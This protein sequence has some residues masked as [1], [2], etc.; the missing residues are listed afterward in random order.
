[1]VVCHTNKNIR[2]M[3]TIFRIFASLSLLAALAS[4]QMYEIDTQ[5]TPAQAAASLRMDC[6]ALATY[7]IPALAPQPLT[8]NVS[9]NTPWRITRSEGSEWLAVSPTS[10]AA[11]GLI[12][13]VVM[14]PQANDTKEDRT[15]VLT[16]AGDGIE[17]FTVIKVIQSR[18]GDLEVIPL[19]KVF[20]AAGGQLPFTFTSNLDWEIKADVDWLTFSL[21]EGPGDGVAHHITITAAASDV[22]ERTGNV[23][24][25]AGEESK[26]FAVSQVGKFDVAEPD[27]VIPSD[28]GNIT[29]KLRTDLPWEIVPD[30]AWVTV[31]PLSQDRGNGNWTDVTVSATANEGAQRKANLKVIA[32]GEEKTIQVSQDGIKFELVAPASNAVASDGEVLVLTVNTAL[33]WTPESDSDW[34]VVAKTDATHMTVTVKW[35]KYFVPRSGMV[36]ITAGSFRDELELTQDTNFTLVGNAVLQDDGTVKVNQD[37][38]SK[39]ITKGTY[40]YVSMVAEVEMHLAAGGQ[41][42]MVTE[43]GYEYQLELNYS[44]PKYRLRSNGSGTAYGEEVFASFGVEQANAMTTARMDFAPNADPTKIDLAFYCNGTQVGGNLTTVSAF[45]GNTTAGAYAIRTDTAITDGSYFIVKSFDI[46]ILDE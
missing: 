40:R 19:S 9:S 27:G 28:G 32:G 20:S 17:S 2:N 3:K 24:V 15:A 35:N 16:L 44:K 37:A 26:S 21:A 38:V 11:G 12:T 1:M 25:T 43:N 18:K 10:S 39:I 8:F 14:T 31:A 5:V 13:D 42:Y 41:F 29:F 30:K 23:T 45:N 6:D 4:C 22:L 33:D 46:T 36:A 7:N 34:L